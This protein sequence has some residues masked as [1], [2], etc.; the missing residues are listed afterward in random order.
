[1]RACCAFQARA[2]ELLFG[3]GFTNVMMKRKTKDMSG[4]WRMRVALARA[5]FASPTL[6]LLVS[7]GES[8]KVHSSFSSSAAFIQERE[9]SK[10]PQLITLKALCS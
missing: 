9:C 7:A 4:G 10:P 3:L 8:G 1:V 6:L 5:L 2:A